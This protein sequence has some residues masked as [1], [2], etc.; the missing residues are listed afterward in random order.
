ML[1]TTH[2]CFNLAS[3]SCGGKY[4]MSFRATPHEYI[5]SDNRSSIR[6]IDVK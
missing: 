5:R 2:L 4:F 6:A 1:C 3:D